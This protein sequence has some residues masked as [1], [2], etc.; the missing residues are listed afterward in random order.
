[1][2]TRWLVNLKNPIVLQATEKKLNDRV[3]PTS[4]RIA[5]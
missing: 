5:Q 3:I 4:P 2:L 1:M